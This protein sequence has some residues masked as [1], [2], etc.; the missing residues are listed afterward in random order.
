MRQITAA[1]LFCAALA[2]S[3]AQAQT[4]GVTADQVTVGV[5]IDLSGPLAEVGRAG[6]NAAR[7]AEEEINAAGGIHGRKLKILFEDQQYDAKKSVL[8]TQKLLEQDKVFAILMSTGTAPAAAAY[9]MVLKSGT[10]HV[11]PWTAGAMF[12]DPMERLSF[13]CFPTNGG[14]AAAGL[15]HMV[16]KE[17]KKRFCLIYQDDE[18]GAEVKDAIDKV[19]GKASLKVIEESGYKRGATDYSAQVARVQRGNCDALLLAAVPPAAAAIMQE[20]Q[21]RAWKIDVLGAAPVFDENTI[22]LGKDAV[23]G[24]YAVGFIASPDAERSS[25]AVQDWVKKYQARHGQPG[26]LYSAYAYSFVNIMAEG[27]RNAGRDLTVESFV[28]GMEAIKSYKTVFGADISFSDKTRL[29]ASGAKL[30]RVQGGKWMELGDLS[31]AS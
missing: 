25:P 29:G 23:E 26:S 9:P 28:K 30:F 2:I 27:L 4:P 12:S 11:C 8:A 10:P 3:P 7:M 15:K 5:P 6:Q 31:P 20:L 21:R 13:A 16:E 1:G 17:A 24:M 14:M 22:K 18:Y 19:L